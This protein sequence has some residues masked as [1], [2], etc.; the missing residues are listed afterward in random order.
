MAKG[1][2]KNVV[3]LLTFDDWEILV[4]NGKFAVQ[5]HSFRADE[6]LEWVCDVGVFTF[7]EVYS[8]FDG[9]MYDERDRYDEWFNSIKAQHITAE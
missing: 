5:G 8:E 3:K 7:E 1:K 4:I 9:D 6:I 2:V